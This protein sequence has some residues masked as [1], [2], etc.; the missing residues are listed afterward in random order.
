MVFPP[1]LHTG[2][3]TMGHGWFSNKHGVEELLE[4][5]ELSAAIDEDTPLAPLGSMFIARRE[6]LQPLLDLKLKWIDF[7]EN[8]DYS[9]GTL[10]HIIE[11]AYGYLPSAL[12]MHTQTVMS[13]N[14]IGRDYTALEYKYQLLAS[15]LPAWPSEQAAALKSGDAVEP[16]LAIVKQRV[17][18]R[19]PGV[20]KNVA[21]VYGLMRSVKNRTRQI[22]SKGKG[23]S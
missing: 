2:Y 8:K 3:P 9:D 20:A 16:L 21:P 10:A 17:K 22:I 15:Q 4:R 14:R 12:G 19:F 13:T 6:V 5:M 1:V 11:R 7:P 23:R 18:I